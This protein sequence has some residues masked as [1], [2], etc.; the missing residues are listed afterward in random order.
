MNTIIAPSLLSADFTQLK[1]EFS[2]LNKSNAEWI[3]LDVMDGIFVPNISFGIPIIEQCRKLSHKHF[4]VH[5]MITKPNLYIEKFYQAGA[6]SISFHI[7]TQ[8][9]ASSINLVKQCGILCGIAINPQTPIQELVPYLKKIN[10]VCLMSVQPGFGGQKFIASSIE[11]IK[12]LKII[13][14]ELKINFDIQVDGGVTLENAA[15]IKNAGAS[16]LVAGNTVFKS[17]KPLMTIDKLKEI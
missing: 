9:V 15:E 5:L 11:K 13:K 4:D 3:H 12:E 2:W 1:N 14:N 17:E 8:D 6:N 10:F 16:I 7:E